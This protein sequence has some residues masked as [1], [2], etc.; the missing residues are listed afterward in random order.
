M[1]EL[2]TL[3][4]KKN[5][6]AVFWEEFSSSSITAIILAIIT[7]IFLGGVLVVVTTNEVYAAFRVSI[8]EGLKTSILTAWNTYVA[9]FNGGV[10][11]PAKI[12][13]ALQSGDADQIRWALNPFLESMVQAT[14][15]MFGGLGVA[16]GFRVGLFNIGVEGQ[17]FM[18]AVAA[19]FAGYA[20]HGLPA[21]IHMPLALLCGALGGAIWGF[22]P[23][24]LKAKTGAHEVI[25][26]I[27][28]NYIA[29]RL[30][31]YLLKFP[32][33]DPNEYTP[34]TPWILETAKIPQLF[35]HPIRFHYGF[36]IAL[37]MAF[38]VY[39]LLFKTSWG[40]ELRMVGLNPSAARYAGIRIQ[41][42]TVLAMVI[43]ASLAAM[44]GANEILAVN[45][46][47]LPAFSSGY[48]FDSLT[49]ALLGKNHPLGVVL[50]ALLFGFL[51]SGAR[52]M[53]IAVGTPIDIVS[54][55]QALILAFI[56]APAIIR[57]I[58]RLKEPKHV[59]D[60]VSLRGWKG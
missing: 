29:F 46:R 45:H 33:H 6:L 49:L 42:A 48:G 15:Y 21:Y 31:D 52:S 13:A 10:G 7:G 58:Y 14:P 56:A 12:I 19:S 32:M 2:S 20:F 37:G 25:T 16:L 35:G 34:K 26:T 41:I 9:L 4:N 36:F 51:K 30:T 23:G 57:S 38:L 55:L 27:M 8:L 24:I 43:S 17:I 18:G 1:A 59:E 44:A 22:V 40:M 3:E 11:N 54:I 5:R 47:L 53:Q 28:M 39:L 60:L 50:S